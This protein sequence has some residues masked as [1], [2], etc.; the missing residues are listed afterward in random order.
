MEP[1]LALSLYDQSKHNEFLG[2]GS[3]TSRP[4]RRLQETDRPIDRLT[5]RQTGSQGSFKITLP[6]VTRKDPCN[7]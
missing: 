5:D 3:G 2:H 4:I 1:N 7:L 6:K